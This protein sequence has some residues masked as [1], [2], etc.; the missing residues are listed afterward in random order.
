[1]L[2]YMLELWICSYIPEVKVPGL[3]QGC[4]C[5]CAGVCV[6]VC[7]CVCVYVCVRE[8]DRQTDRQRQKESFKYCQNSRMKH[9]AENIST[10]IFFAVG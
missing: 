9:S 7:V 2:K 10:L 6:C 8:T 1:M 5:T 4:V 3:K